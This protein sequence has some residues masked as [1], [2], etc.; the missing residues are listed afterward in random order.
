[1]SDERARAMADRLARAAASVE[2]PTPDINRLLAAFQFGHE[3]RLRVLD[4]SHHP[5][6]LHG[7]RSALILLE[8]F[9]LLDPDALALAALYESRFPHL[10]ADRASIEAV[11]G[12]RALAMVASLPTDDTGEETLEWLLAAEPAGLA[13]ALAER[14]DHARHLHLEPRAHWAPFHHNFL[15]RYLPATDRVHPRLARRCRWWTDMFARRYLRP[16][17]ENPASQNT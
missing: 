8:D 17:G 6:A 3:Q 15:T 16:A 12:P 1:V 7:A 5:Q 2:I 11:A 10:R 4:D 9:A 13:L 14:L